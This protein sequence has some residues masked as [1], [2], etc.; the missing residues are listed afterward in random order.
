VLDRDDALLVIVDV[1][2]RLADAMPRR[3]AV[4][5]TCVLLARSAGILGIPVVV[6]RQYPQGL[7]DTVPELLEAL[8]D[9][10]PVDKGTFSCP[11][12]PSF[13]RAV[14]DSGRRQVVLAGMETHICITQTAL[15]LLDAGYRVHV[16][17]DATCSR[18]DANHEVALHRLRSAGA[19]VTTA[20]SAIY[21]ALGEAGTPEFRSVLEVVKAHPIAG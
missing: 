20:E 5:G 21:E 15:A 13:E 9:V 11:A 18:R 19:V 1:Q 3:D 2:C 12:E 14:A 10:Q 6:T 16:V 7:G 17:A 8:P 4:V